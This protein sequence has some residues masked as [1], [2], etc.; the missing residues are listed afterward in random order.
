MTALFAALRTLVFAGFFFW[1]WTTLGLW[2]SRFDPVFGGPLP[3]WTRPVGA[4]FALAGAALALTCMGLFAI[5]GKGTPAPFDPPRRLVAF[6][7][8]RA[9]RNPMYIGGWL[10]IAGFA[11]IGRSSSVLVFSFAFLVLAHFFVILY[12]EPTLT[13]KFGP[14]YDNYRRAVPRWIPKLANW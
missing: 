14:A 11:M 1:L 6:G 9:I 12:E 7:P 4:V 8:Y 3:S 13:S 2:A 5:R 10:L